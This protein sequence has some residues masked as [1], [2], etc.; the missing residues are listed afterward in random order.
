MTRVKGAWLASVAVG[1]VVA[2]CATGPAYT[3]KTDRESATLDALDCN[4]AAIVA[5][6]AT[7]KKYADPQ[8]EG[9]RRKAALAA[10]AAW[11]RCLVAHG[12]KKRD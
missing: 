11:R 3:K 7:R 6:R 10:N 4:K 2:G 5:H 12:W 8:S 9:A 1:A